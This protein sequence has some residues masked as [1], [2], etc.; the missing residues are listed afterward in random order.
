MRIIGRSVVRFYQSELD[1]SLDT[2]AFNYIEMCLDNG[3]SDLLRFFIVILGVFVR[4]QAIVDELQ[5]FLTEV[6]EDKS[7]LFRIMIDYALKIG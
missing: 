1:L 2:M 6:E 3:D 5:T 7:Q 4:N